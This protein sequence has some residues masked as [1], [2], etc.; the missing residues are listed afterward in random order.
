MKNLEI[1]S[2]NLGRSFIPIKSDSRRRKITS[3]LEKGNYDIIMLQ[4]DNLEKNVDFKHLGYI[5]SS[6]DNKKTLTLSNIN[7]PV[8]SGGLEEG[9]YNSSIIKYKGRKLVCVNI[10]ARS[11]SDMSK[12]FDVCS[13]YS[14][15]KDE[16]YAENR[17][18][19]GR[20]PRE[21][22]TNTFCDLF[23][24][25]D[26]STLIGQETHIKN[27]RE[28]LNH[29]FVSRNLECLNVH[30]LVG[31]TEVSKLGEAYPIEASLSYKKVLK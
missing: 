16:N 8:Y 31:M 22:D 12:V 28:M 1:L 2:M 26:V 17:I 30:K 13:R 27:K 6:P 14:N 7:F 11:E 25:E 15:P 9:L 20:L 23:D 18:I 21:V 5:Y 10:N 3:L 29:L 19:A 24:L 4:G